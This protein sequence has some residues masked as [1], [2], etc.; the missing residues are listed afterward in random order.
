MEK[1]RPRE[2]NPLAD[3][4]ATITAMGRNRDLIASAPIPDP[5][6]R[7]FLEDLAMLN[8]E[9]VIIGL[10]TPWVRQVAV[11]I[12]QAWRLFQRTVPED[13]REDRKQHTLEILDQCTDAA[14]RERC[15]DWVGEQR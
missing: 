13:A 8:E 14:L 3:F 12:V 1:I 6:W 5:G 11:P 2:I 4:V 15:R 10:R 7:V 9:G